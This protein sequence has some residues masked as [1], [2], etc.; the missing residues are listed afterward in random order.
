MPAIVLEWLNLLVRWVHVIAAIMWIGDSFLFMWLDSH[1]SKPK[2]GR[3]ENVT[4]ELWMTHS[5]GFYEVM[6]RKSLRKGESVGTLYWFKW[7]S[8]TTWLSGFCLIAIVYWLGGA[9][10]L[11]DPTVAK[12]SPMAAAHVSLLLLPAGYLVYE[13]LWLTPLAKSQR[14][15]AAVGLVLITAL[16]W[17]LTQLFSGRGAFLQVGAMLGTIMSANVFFRIIPSQKHM[18]AAT[19]AGTPVDTSY[20]LRAKGRSI[21][22]HYLT[23]P[24]LFCMLSNHFPSTYGHPQAWAVLGLLVVVGAGLKYVMNFRGATHPFVFV[25]TAM[26]LVVVI[27]LTVRGSG[28][29][30]S[31]LAAYEGKP[32]VSFATVNTIVQARCVTCHATAPTSP[33]FP[34][35]PNGIVL[36]TPEQIARQADRMFVRSVSTK[37]MP[38]GNMTGMTDE[39][40]DLLGAWVAQG[41][42]VSAAG[43][44]AIAAPAVVDAGA[45]E[46]P[47][48]DVSPAAL[49]KHKFKNVCAVCHGE[50]G[51]AQTPAAAAFLVKPRNFRDPEWQKATTDEAIRTIILK[52]GVAVGKSA[53]M[54][55]N[56]D[57]EAKPEVVD[58][59]V[60][61]IR[62]FGQ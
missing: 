29:G 39:E 20:G 58:E 42:D 3:D 18:L 17:Q 1:L 8:Y 46:E 4:G 11:I 12:L 25:G 36:E 32:K 53:T 56:Q 62:G 41:K 21:Q 7:E 43:A 50:N 57:L 48:R 6:K 38:L 59:L 34:A 47:V 9:A 24:V 35:P 51:D 49:A 16:A 31:G 15:F 37:T 61:I 54:P 52:G 44:S 45:A 40:R 10:L 14:A 22:N 26:A 28:D 5:G 2:E 19:E 55:P 23:L 13:G 33:M 27:G 60:K 30:L